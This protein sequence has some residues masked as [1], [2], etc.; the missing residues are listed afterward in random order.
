MKK[1]DRIAV[2]LRDEYARALLG[3]PQRPEPS[4]WAAIG[5]YKDEDSYGGLWIALDYV[6]ERRR[7]I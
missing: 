7:D 1:G 5:Q 3:A 2:W 6:D 4:R